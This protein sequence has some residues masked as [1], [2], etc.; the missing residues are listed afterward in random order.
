[1]NMEAFNSSLDGVEESTD[2]NLPLCQLFVDSTCYF[3][4]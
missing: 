4:S 2:G 1:M 3:L